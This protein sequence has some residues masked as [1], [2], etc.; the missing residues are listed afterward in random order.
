MPFTAKQPPVRLS[1]LLAVDDAADDV[2]LR[3]VACRPDEKVEVALPCTVRKPVVVA[4]PEMVSPVAC[5]PA[6]T[7]EEASARNP[8]VSMES[9]VTPSVEVAVIAPPKK[10]LPE[11]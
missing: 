1:P 4:P 11:W 2:R 8:P 10:A 6:P 5:P 7:V 9:P 3:V